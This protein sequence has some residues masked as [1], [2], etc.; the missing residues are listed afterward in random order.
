MSIADDRQTT[1]SGPVIQS[2]SV[3][4]PIPAFPF[5]WLWVKVQFKGPELFMKKGALF[6]EVLY[7]P[8]YIALCFHE[9]V[10]DTIVDEWPHFGCIFNVFTDLILPH[11]SH[12]M[13]A[14]PR[15]YQQRYRHVVVML[16]QR[17]TGWA[18]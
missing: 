9:Q 8:G 2:T 3:Y 17:M 11:N 6:Q 1:K 10:G 12:D 15:I 5:I 7:L 18:S 13:T 4:E 14:S 16:Y